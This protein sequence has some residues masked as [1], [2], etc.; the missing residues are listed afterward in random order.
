MAEVKIVS[1]KSALSTLKN[2]QS[3][4]TIRWRAPETIGKRM[5]NLIYLVYQ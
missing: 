1:S 5:Q 3:I 2:N 4:G